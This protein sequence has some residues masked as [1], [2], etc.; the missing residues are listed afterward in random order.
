MT[1]TDTITDVADY[2][3]RHRARVN[4]ARLADYLDALPDDYQHFGM[5]AYWTPDSLMA[6]DPRDPDPAHHGCRTAACAVGHGP[7]ALGLNP[8]QLNR[9]RSSWDRSMARFDFYAFMC[10]YL[11]VETADETYNKPNGHLPFRWM[12]DANWSDTDDTPQGAAA[13]IRHYLNHGAPAD[14]Y[15]QLNGVGYI[16]DKAVTA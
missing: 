8:L 4:L 11:R 3:R 1:P 9:Y 13:R 2:R 7:A 10:D 6:L 5:L 14:T 16:F 12:F 15:D